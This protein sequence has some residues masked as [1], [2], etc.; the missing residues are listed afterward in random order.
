MSDYLDLKA[1]LNNIIGQVEL[2]FDSSGGVVL[3]VD[4]AAAAVFARRQEIVAHVHGACTSAAYWIACAASKIIL[5]NRTTILGSIGIKAQKYVIKKR[6][7]IC[8]YAFC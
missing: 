5:C 1:K 2:H 6:R 3:G 8:A 4:E 7:N